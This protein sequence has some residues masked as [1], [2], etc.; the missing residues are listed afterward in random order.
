[1]YKILNSYQRNR[2]PQS[3]FSLIEL[4]I[5]VLIIGIST[6]M[7]ILY[8]DTSDERLKTEA[9]R[10][11]AMTQL[12]RDEAIITGQ[13][14]G[15][16]VRN[17]EY[18]FLLFQDEEWKAINKQ[19]YQKIELS[20]D[21]LLRTMVSDKQINSVASTLKNSNFIYFLPT[22]E[23]SQFQIWLTNKDGAEFLLNG[24]LMGGL[25]L[26]KLEK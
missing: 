14:Y 20:D 18:Y 5:V 7:A 15:M 12:A 21:I 23:M 25:S 17:Q 6:S 26:E 1:M 13:S 2:M 24:E 4:M 9:H 19:P 10:L 8:I 22:G 16:I 11:L 3:G